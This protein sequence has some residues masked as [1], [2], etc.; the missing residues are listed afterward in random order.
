MMHMHGTKFGTAV[1]TGNGFARIEYASGIK[2]V[3]QGV[4]L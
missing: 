4:K 2:G 1:Q 3:F